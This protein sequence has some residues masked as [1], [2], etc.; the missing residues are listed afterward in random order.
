MIGVIGI[1][2]KSA[3][4]EI[5]ERF[6]LNESEIISFINSLIEQKRIGKFVVLS[7][8]N[9]TEIYF[10][11][12]KDCKASNY[13]SII[14]AFIRLWNVRYE[15]SELKKYFYAYYDKEA[16]KHLFK[17]ASG[18][19]AMV[20]GEDQI[21]GQVKEAFRISSEKEFTGAVL[22]KLFH[23]TFEIGKKARTLTAINEGAS[24]VSSVAVELVANYFK[25]IGK[26]RV[27][28]IGA[29]RTGELTLKCLLK[30]G[31]KNVF[32][33]NRDLA[34]AQKLSDSYS[35]KAVAFDDIKKHII[36]C[37]IVI[38]STASKEPVINRTMIKHA[39]R[40]RNKRTLF[41]ID[42]SVPRNVE[43]NVKDIENVML[44]DIDDLEEVI[45]KNY[46][47]RVFEIEK[48]NKLI[49]KYTDDFFA[50]FDTLY[51]IPAIIALKKKFEFINN[52]ELE[53]YKKKINGQEFKTVQEY[54][55][56]IS[57]RY[58]NMIVENL[59]SLSQ[60][61]KK[62]EYLEFVNELFKL[63]HLTCP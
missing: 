34:K 19:D 58:V 27:F 3:P 60:N 16:V 55:N 20:L 1:S 5:R 40:E 2:F 17:V 36:E 9:R 4:V 15:I 57:E 52:H 6:T 7:T 24:S 41:L 44:F 62:I 28:L 61:G 37:D 42:I 43:Q 11:L 47:K 45:K 63:K 14:K 54:G 59:V 13:S 31:A 21:L 38:I 29:G 8:C 53:T 25:E 30:K 33:T 12:I 56:Y 18:L 48:V 50:W 23:K 39:M 32:I 26:H 49:D 10:H 22:N 35:G 51:L 46:S